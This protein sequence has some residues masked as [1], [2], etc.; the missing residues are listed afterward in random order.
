MQQ[1]ETFSTPSWV[2]D[3]V[4]YQIFPD[5]FA[6]SPHVTKPSN[7]EPW[8]SPPTVHGFKGGDLLGVVEK[9]DYLQDLGITA[10]YFTP[11]FASTAN[12]RYHT[13][14]YFRVDPI[15]GGDN[16]LRTLI[17][18]AH[19]RNMRIVLD[20]VFNHASRGFFQFN[21]LL[22]NG[23]QSP[24]IDWFTVTS[25]PLNAYGSGDSGY[26]AW[27]NLPD[28]PEF[29]TSVQAVREF[30]W[31]VGTYWIEQGIDG[32]RLDVPN[33]IDDDEFWREFRRRVKALNSEAY[34]V[35]E[36]WGDARRWLSGDQF[37]GVMN[38]L[39]TRACLG[40][41]GPGDRGLDD[42]QFRRTGL[43]PV[44]ELDASGFRAAVETILG[45]YPWEA[46]KAQ[47]N[48]LDSHDTPRFL[49]ISREDASSLQL[50]TL[51]QMTFPGAPCIYY[52]DEV[53]MT[54]GRDPDCRRSFLWDESTW[55]AEIRDWVRRCVA[56][57][58][59]HP[60]L[61]QG[62]FEALEASHDVFVF[63]RIHDQK[64]AIIA[65]NAGQEAAEA[66]VT[67]P[68]RIRPDSVT[69]VWDGLVPAIECGRVSNWHIPARSGSV[70]MAA[71]VG[72]V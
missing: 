69:A 7:L 30:L 51:F 14:D 38:Y 61:R 16:A 2:H 1:T 33:E 68:V 45:L 31:D 37:D 11:V 41:F 43:W 50:S 5:R 26:K 3:A 9:L 40:F 19:R 52:G 36:I 25:W 72:Q 49:S 57:R 20:G 32:W 70:L 34:I 46:T 55:S 42:S 21:H 53:G 4:F 24:Y 23:A 59:A 64:I 62:A 63:C 6:H 56:L 67:L 22:E 71:T 65:L 10:I 12:H 8:D 39:F 18:E 60:I 44:P 66:D 27:W 58:H 54:G 47:L 48:L 29:D 35:G 17:D 13:Y 15:L 28:L